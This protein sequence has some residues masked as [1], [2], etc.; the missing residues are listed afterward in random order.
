MTMP[1][2][3]LGGLAWVVAAGWVVKTVAAAR[4]LPRIADLRRQE[5]DRVP[6][7]EPWVTVVVPARDEAAGVVECLE[8]LVGQDYGRLRVIAVDDRS[9]DGTGE[10][11]EAL[12]GRFPG[13]LRVLH[14]LE[15]PPG[16][17]GK[18]HAMAWAAREALATG[19]AEFL[20]FTDADVVFRVD[21]VRRSLVRAVESGADHMVTVPTMLVRRWDEGMVLGF[22]Q[23]FG[24]WAARPWLVDDPKAMRDAVGIGAFNMLRGS[25]Y[26]GLGGFE[27]QKM[28]ILEDVVLAQRVKRAGLRQRIAFGRGMVEVHWAAGATGLMGVMTKT[29]FAALRFN[30]GLVAGVCAWIAVFLMGPVVGIW[31]GPT[32]LA[33]GIALACVL[34]G[35][36]LYGRTSG[37]SAWYFV[38]FPFGAW[39]FLVTLVRSMA[40]TLWHGGVRWRGTF[41]SLEELRRESGSWR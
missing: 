26:V 32:R 34:W 11:M 24:L 27:G 21:A 7:G 12:A 2:Y 18:T 13:R 31:W 14:V 41:Y 33:S 39:A 1:H 15:L 8:S 38:L 3:G 17:L 25:A 6:E 20:L 9:T 16:W 5:F 35:Y 29:I 23:I 36:R 4:G 10:L 22:F 19:E 37:I 28:E 40:V 30:V